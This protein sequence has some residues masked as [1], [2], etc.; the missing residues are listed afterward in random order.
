MKK[1]DDVSLRL[2]GV[3]GIGF[4][5]GE[6]DGERWSVMLAAEGFEGEDGGGGGGD[7]MGI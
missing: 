6:A 2:E 7:M 3:G 1:R 5:E 4:S